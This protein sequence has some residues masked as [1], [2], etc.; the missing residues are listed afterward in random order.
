MTVMLY[1]KDGEHA[2]HG[3]MFDTIIVNEDDV[4]AAQKDGWSLTT[5]EALKPA[6]KKRKPAK[7]VLVETEIETVIPEGFNETSEES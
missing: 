7:N 5:T 4:K 1:K 2:I 3:G 6:K